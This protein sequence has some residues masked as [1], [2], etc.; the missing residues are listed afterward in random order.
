MSRFICTW[1]LN[2]TRVGYFSG[3][4]CWFHMVLLWYHHRWCH[5]K[6][7]VHFY[8]SEVMST[9]PTFCTWAVCSNWC[10]CEWV[11]GPWWYS[12]AISSQPGMYGKSAT[13]RPKTA[14]SK[15]FWNEWWSFVL[16]LI[17]TGFEFAYDCWNRQAAGASQN[18]VAGPHLL[19]LV[20]IRAC[21]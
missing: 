16:V 15:F 3:W 18:K 1:L 11:I 6:T 17:T 21:K 10:A 7:V 19:N 20:W 13:S 8:A 9:S 12:S 5:L 4:Y 2:L 14:L